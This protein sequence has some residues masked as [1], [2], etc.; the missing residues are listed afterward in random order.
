MPQVFFYLRNEDVDLWK[1]LDKKSEF[2]HNALNRE[3][4]STPIVTTRTN[5]ERIVEAVQDSPRFTPKPPDHQTG[6]PCCQGKTPCKH[7]QW[8]TEKTAYVNTLTGETR[9]PVL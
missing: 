8:S 9:E 1:A 3:T 7:W 6:Y 5:A 2:I 4:F